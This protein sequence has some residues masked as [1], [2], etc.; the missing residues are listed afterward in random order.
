MN[1]AGA[2]AASSFVTLIA[3]FIMGALSV[4]F[5]HRRLLLT[6]LLVMSLSAV[7]CAFSTSYY[8]MLLFF[9]LNGFG[10]ALIMPMT[11][12]LTAEH[13]QKE[14]RASAIGWI[15]MGVPV[16]ADLKSNIV[17]FSHVT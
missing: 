5:S 14:A 17:F 13:L 10:S 9:S 11:M 8:P 2:R 1:G 15:L 4:R 7:A 6:G 3:S 12:S 16:S